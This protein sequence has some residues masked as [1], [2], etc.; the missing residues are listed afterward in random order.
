MAAKSLKKFKNVQISQQEIDDFKRAIAQGNIE[1]VERVL[2]VYGVFCSEQFLLHPPIVLAATNENNLEIMKLLIQHNASVNDMDERG[3]TPLMVASL[4]RNREIMKYLIENKGDIYLLDNDK[5]TG[6][7]YLINNIK[8][9]ELGIMDE[10]KDNY[11]YNLLDEVNNLGKTALHIAIAEKNVNLVKKLLEIGSSVE[12][13][14]LDGNS[15][16]LLA[17]C[18]GNIDIIK[19]ILTHK[20]SSID[21]TYVQL[22][23]FLNFIFL[24]FFHFMFGNK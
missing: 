4:L 1:A 18:N 10:F 5:N 15:P 19:L 17:C 23:I 6:L 14:D 13:R 3:R 11:V 21:D 8:D 20:P 2:I 12:S 16:F 22:S 7:H 24:F 9:E